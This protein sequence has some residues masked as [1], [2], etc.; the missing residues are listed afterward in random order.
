VTRSRESILQE[1]LV[2][3]CQRGDERAVGELIHQ[4]QDRLF[5]FLRRLVA[6]EQDTWDVL[7]QTWLKVHRNIKTLNSPDRLP[8][9]LYAI[10]RRTALS[11]WRGRYRREAFAEEHKD[12]T[13]VPAADVAE[14][15]D[16]AEQVH[17]G[18]SRISPAHREILSLH[19]LEEFS[20]DDLS[21]ILGIPPG[22]AKSRLFYA[23]RA[24]RAVLEGDET[25]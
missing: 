24:L 1:L 15:F 17:Q 12:L 19:F 11:H 10:A 21:E 13:D 18:L 22:T 3:R 14:A 2:L 20:V 6:S 7:Q 23:K 16:D 9:W 4:W 5:Y 25:P 8:V